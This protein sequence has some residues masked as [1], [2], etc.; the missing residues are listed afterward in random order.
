MAQS[1]VK[2]F[3]LQFRCKIPE[4]DLNSSSYNTDWLEFTVPFKDGKPSECYR[5]E[6]NIDNPT[7]TADNFNQS[8]AILC[9]DFIYKGD[10]KTIVNEWDLTCDENQWKITLVGTV[11]YFG[12]FI[13][14]LMTGYLSDIYGRRTVFIL[15]T[16]ASATIGLMKSFSVNY[17][18]FIIME[19]LD[20]AI[21]SGLYSA[22]FVLGIYSNQN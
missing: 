14:L 16:I 20:P 6:A 22:G 21:G 2:D 10:E 4:C 9:N 18:M 12:E 1:R 8:S 15:G 3:S 17:N 11:Q 7:C 5:Y 13:C 19:F